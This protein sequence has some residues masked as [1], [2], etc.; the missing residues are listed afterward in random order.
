[1]ERIFEGIM[2][3]LCGLIKSKPD[4]MPKVEYKDY[5]VVKSKPVGT[6]ITLLV[7]L[8]IAIIFSVLAFFVD[9]DTRILF[10]IFMGL[11]LI[12][13]L[14]VFLTAT[15]QCV[16]TNRTITK[17]CLFLHKVYRW[18]DIICV[19]KCEKTDDNSVVIAL[20]NREG[21]CV[22]DVLSEMDNAWYLVKMAEQKGIAIRTG[23]DLSLKE[24][25]RLKH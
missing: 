20:Y 1:M 5:F 17:K 3:S 11:A 19:Q 22:V 6:V 7:F 9:S 4:Q 12:L 24:I 15:Y 18:D 14:L 2:E 23:K 8:A 10:F 13:S 21:K 25:N 16:V